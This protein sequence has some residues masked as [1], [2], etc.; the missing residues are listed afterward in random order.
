MSDDATV[1]AAG[2]MRGDLAFADSL[3]LLD[4]T[5]ASVRLYFLQRHT[6]GP[7]EISKDYV[8]FGKSCML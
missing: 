5:T 7:I 4:E 3:P 8:L 6:F 1:P 2:S